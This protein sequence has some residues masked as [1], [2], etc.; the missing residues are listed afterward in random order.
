VCL[1]SLRQQY[2]RIDSSNRGK[3]VDVVRRAEADLLPDSARI[4][5]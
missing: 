5:N 3:D 2:R 1:S 4:R